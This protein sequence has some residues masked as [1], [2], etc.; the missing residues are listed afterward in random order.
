MTPQTPASLNDL[1]SE[2]LLHVFSHVDPHAGERILGHIS[3]DPP[4]SHPDPYL[5][6]DFMECNSSLYNLALTTKRFRDIAQEHLLFAPVIGGFAFRTFGDRSRSRIAYLLRT[7][8]ARPDLRR[9]VRQIRLC[10]SPYDNLSDRQDC[11]EEA[12]RGAE[13]VE[14]ADIV[15]QSREIITSSDFPEELEKA[16]SAQIIMD[17]R[18]TMLGV[19][20]VLLPQLEVLSFSDHASDSSGSP[21]WWEQD[22]HYFRPNLAGIRLNNGT[23]VDTVALQRLSAA[24]TLKYV[25]I[26]SVSM[27]RL[28]GLNACLQLTTLDISM[29]LAGLDSFFVDELKTLFSERSANSNFQYIRNLRIDCRVKTVGIWDFAART[30]LSH[31]LLPFKSLKSLDYYAEPTSEKNPFRSV[32]AFPHYQANIQTYPD[33]VT[34]DAREE[35]Y[36][37]E[38]LYDARTH[39]T[40]YQYLVDSLVPVRSGLETL[41]LPGGFWTLPGAMRKPLPRFKL[42]PQLRTLAVPQAAILSIKLDNMR[43]P[44]VVKGDF[45]LLPTLVLPPNLQHLRIFDANVELLRSAWLQELFD[46]QTE[47]NQWPNLKVVKLLFGP[48]ID[49]LDLENL[50]GRKSWND[51]WYLADQAH[52]QVFVGRD[53][54]VPAIH[55]TF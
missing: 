8:F 34:D 26:S 29:K 27:I 14:F 55:G 53:N 2:L 37:D 20:M 44:E 46:R 17:F 4:P 38:R 11:K 35:M 1:P 22:D 28:D 52:F 16:M 5:V 50:L 43:F 33:R 42:F 12:N 18:H 40:D 25:K 41:R 30:C 24:A 36:W 45:E 6:K 49:D 15:R 3:D 10:F 13:P 47:C 21:P 32:R 23:G 7:L 54:E 31:L 48:T 39:Y 9:H 19:L 51:F